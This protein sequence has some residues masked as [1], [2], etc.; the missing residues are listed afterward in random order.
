[1]IMAFRRCLPGK[2]RAAGSM[3]PGQCW[4][5][6]NRYWPYVKNTT[7]RGCVKRNSPE[8]LSKTHADC[9]LFFVEI[10]G[11]ITLIIILKRGIVHETGCKIVE[12]SD[13]HLHAAVHA[14]CVHTGRGYARS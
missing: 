8:H 11:K 7:K 2:T 5:I 9:K 4:A 13:G 1:M 3:R 6:R 14:A 10:C 12:P